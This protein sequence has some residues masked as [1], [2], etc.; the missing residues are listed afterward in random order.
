MNTTNII[1]T[2]KELERKLQE[3]KEI[4]KLIIKISRKYPSAYYDYRPGQFG[5]AVQFEHCIYTS[6]DG[7]TELGHG[8]TQLNALRKAVKKI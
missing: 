3:A 6:L 5:D 8:K 4:K 7:D 1:K 2:V